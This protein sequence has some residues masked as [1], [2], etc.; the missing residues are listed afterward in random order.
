MSKQLQVLNRTYALS[1]W[2]RK[3]EGK[4]N[5]YLKRLNQQ[6]FV[7]F[8]MMCFYIWKY[9]K[10]KY[11]YS[12]TNNNNNNS[13]TTIREKKT[14]N[15]STHSSITQPASTTLCRTIHITLFLI[16][17]FHFIQDENE[18]KKNYYVYIVR[19]FTKALLRFFFLPTKWNL[20]FC[21][22]LHFFS[23]KP[24]GNDLIACNVICGEKKSRGKIMRPKKR[25]IKTTPWNGNRYGATKIYGTSQSFTSSAHNVLKQKKKPKAAS[26]SKVQLPQK[27]YFFF[28]FFLN[29]KYLYFI[30]R[31]KR[32][33]GIVFF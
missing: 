1:K 16:Y 5:I 15:I 20:C 27:K 26:S 29:N 22:S 9:R 25:N 18:E 19:K 17:L 12:N 11:I 31:Q 21:I 33:E 4:K 10:E 7:N 2:W 3:R 32:W 24:L 6:P 28:V 14:F 30:Y 13:N 8:S 23:F